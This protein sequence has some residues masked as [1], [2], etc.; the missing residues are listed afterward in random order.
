MPRCRL[1]AILTV[2]LLPAT[3]VAGDHYYVVPCGSVAPTRLPWQSHTWL[4][5]VKATPDPAEPDGWHVEA[6]TVSW[7]PADFTVLAN[8]LTPAAGVNLTLADTLARVAADGQRVS[9]WGPYEVPAAAFDRVQAHAARLSGGGKYLGFDFLSGGPQDTNCVRAAADAAGCG[10]GYPFP[11]TGPAAAQAV[12]TR[13]MLTDAVVGPAADHAWLVPR[14]GL[15]GPGVT[16][17]TYQAGPFGVDWTWRL[18]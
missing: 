5:A 1:Y 14:L 15:A 13:L 18:R 4:T 11:L 17:E 9:V 2:V 6:V 7:F 16:R 10:G 8:L 3:T 12:V